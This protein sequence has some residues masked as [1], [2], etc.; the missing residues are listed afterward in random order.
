MYLKFKQMDFKHLFAYFV[1]VDDKWITFLSKKY[2]FLIEIICIFK[3]FA[4]LLTLIN[5]NILYI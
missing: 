3:L 4:I 2:C 5:I 1:T